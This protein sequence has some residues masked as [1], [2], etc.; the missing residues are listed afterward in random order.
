MK[1][2]SGQTAVFSPPG[3]L[4]AMIST[5]TK[6]ST[7]THLY[8][9]TVQKDSRVCC[10]SISTITNNS[11]RVIVAVG[12]SLP[13]LNEQRTQLFVS[14]HTFTRRN[15]KSLTARIQDD[16]IVVSTRLFNLSIILIG[17]HRHRQRRGGFS[18]HFFFQPLAT[19]ALF[20]P[21]LFSQA[22]ATRLSVRVKVCAETLL[23][24]ARTPPRFLGRAR[25]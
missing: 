20:S 25:S 10:V 2:S 15:E 23:F 12:A 16:I 9:Q 21:S 3:E 14:Y 7:R 5:I 6:V 24:T 19:L 1:D 22:L 13:K 4:S 8:F 17:N 11:V 18:R